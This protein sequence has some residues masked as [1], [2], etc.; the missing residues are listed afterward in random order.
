MSGFVSKSWKN[1]LEQGFNDLKRTQTLDFNQI[2]FK[3][4]RAK[5]DNNLFSSPEYSFVLDGN[6]LEL[7]ADFW[8]RHMWLVL[9][10]HHHH[11]M[12][13]LMKSVS[14]RPLPIRRPHK[15][16]LGTVLSR[17]YLLTSCYLHDIVE[18]CLRVRDF[19]SRTFTP[20]LQR[21]CLPCGTLFT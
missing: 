15:M 4:G 13:M 18:G 5:L 19:H 21:R 8:A 7:G 17:P 1:I 12:I 20:P 16:L 6:L 14:R 10:F 2:L 11:L 3:F 9:S